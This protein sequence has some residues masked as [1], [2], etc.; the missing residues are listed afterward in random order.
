MGKKLV[1]KGWMPRGTK[2]SK[3]CFWELLHA[4]DIFISKGTCDDYHS[5]D[6]PP[7]RVTVTVEVDNGK[8]A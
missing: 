4:Y 3:E 7:V 1:F 8:T 5:V 6:W 2:I